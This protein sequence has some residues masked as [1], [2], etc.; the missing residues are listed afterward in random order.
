MF[1]CQRIG[2]IAHCII[3]SIFRFIEATLIKTPQVNS[4]IMQVFV[5]LNLGSM[6]FVYKQSSLTFS[7]LTNCLTFLFFYCVWV[8]D[9][10]LIDLQVCERNKEFISTLYQKS[11]WFCFTG[12]SYIWS[13][14]ENIG[15]YFPSVSSSITILLNK[16]QSFQNVFLATCCTCISQDT[17]QPSPPDTSYCFK[18][19]N[20]WIACIY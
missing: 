17:E 1:I 2:I 5:V 7:K 9:H 11:W 18:C 12:L 20:A 10:I 13:A 8:W 3:L 6:Y 19:S 4:G 14:W 16:Q 15:A